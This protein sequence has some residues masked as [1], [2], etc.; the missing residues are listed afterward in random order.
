MVA[1]AGARVALPAGGLEAHGV[2][3]ADANGCRRTLPSLEPR[4]S[5]STPHIADVA[6]LMI[7]GETYATSS[8]SDIPTGGFRRAP[9]RRPDCRTGFARS[10]ISTPS[11]RRTAKTL[12]DYL[13]DNGGWANR[14]TGGGPWRWLGE[15]R[16]GR[17]SFFAVN[18]ADAPLGGQSVHD[19]T[20]LSSF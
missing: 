1:G 7:W 3:H 10:S 13:P 14:K 18:A 2:F 9:R 5:A 8:W 16:R 12:F 17:R 20:P 19:A 15:F 6:N 11:F 4:R